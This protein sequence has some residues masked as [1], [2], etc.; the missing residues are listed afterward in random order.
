MKAGDIVG[1]KYRLTRQLGAGAMGAVWE[2]VNEKTGRR[3]ALK[4]I[5]H[6]TEDL[7]RRLL[8]E[9]KACGG[10]AHRNIIEVYDVGETAAGDP[11]LVL[12]LLSGETL[13]D[14]LKARRRLDPPLAARIGRDIANA[15]TAA[16]AAQVVHRD[17][18]P[19]NV[20][21]HREDGQA[22][23]EFTVKVLD[24]GVSKN[25]A[26]SDGPATFT[27]QAVGSPAYMSP[28]QVQTVKDLDYRTDIWSFGIVLY[29]ML[30]GTRPFVGTVS[31]VV[32]MILTAPIP[33][34]SSRVRQLPPELDEIV[35]RCLERDRDKRISDASHI[36]K[37]LSP[38]GDGRIQSAAETSALKIAS[39]QPQHASVTQPL[40]KDAPLPVATPPWQDEIQVFLAAKRQSGTVAPTGTVD[41]TRASPAA[42]HAAV[43]V[44]SHEKPLLKAK[45]VDNKHTRAD[46][47]T[48]AARVS[49]GWLRTALVGGAC[50]VVALAIL[51]VVAA[52]TTASPETQSMTNSQPP[53]NSANSPSTSSQPPTNS[54][55]LAEM[56]QP[57]QAVPVISAAP[58]APPA[59]SSAPVVVASAAVPTT[60]SVTTPVSLASPV[61]VN[62]TSKPIGG[63]LKPPALKASSSSSSNVPRRLFGN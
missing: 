53:T 22:E 54:S 7:R 36:V 26:A 60:A 30:T 27:G 63:P 39:Q 42:T 45:A 43:T 31:D 49:L 35:A 10:L 62:A 12:Q 20:F 44:T 3:V 19:A 2:A 11:F 34:V 8:R 24:F 48:A 16:H 52:A 1:E 47:T 29:E 15:L 40:P 9:A 18:K 46:Q 50:A 51:L 23:H 21:L 41:S 13:A 17:L 32:T 6:S 56:P 57:A 58:P 25:L 28:E 14:F 37:M 55:T 61:K 4:L 59:Q 38:I 5:L 33:P